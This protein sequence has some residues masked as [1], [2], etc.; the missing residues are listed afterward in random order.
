[1]W[2]RKE[3]NRLQDRN[4][5]INDVV[6]FLMSQDKRLLTLWGDPMNGRSSILEKAIKIVIAHRPEIY[7]KRPMYQVHQIDM[8]NKPRSQICQEIVKVLNLQIKE[9]SIDL[10]SEEL[11]RKK[12]LL[13]FKDCK[14][15]KEEENVRELFKILRQLNLNTQHSN[16]HVKT[17][18][19]LSKKPKDQNREYEQQIEIPMMSPEGKCMFFI[20]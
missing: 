16:A 4:L 8:G 3:S 10:I 5:Y 6:E 11:S 2:L 18:V 17:V 19:I 14:M 7:I 12:M 9:P 20:H 13:Y 1:M 15:L